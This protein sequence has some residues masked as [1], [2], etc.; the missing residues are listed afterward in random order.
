MKKAVLIVLATLIA[1]SAVFAAPT[2]KDYP[3][4]KDMSDPN[5]VKIDKFINDHSNKNETAVFD[6]DGT[7]Y[8]EKI[9]CK[10]FEG[11]KDQ[12]LP[13]QVS[14]LVYTAKNA[15]KFN[16]AVYPT[17]NH[18]HDTL[19]NNVNTMIKI[20]ENKVKDQKTSTNP[21][22][23]LI[24]ATFF[25]LM[26][27]AQVAETVE[28]FLQEETYR[29][30][31][32]MY[33]PMFDVFQKMIDSG[34]NVYIITGSNEYIV[35]KMLDNI[36]SVDYNGEKNYTF[37]NNLTGNKER[38]YE[39][40]GGHIMGNSPYLLDG[41]TGVF[42]NLSDY[43]WAANTDGDGKLYVV[44]GKGKEYVMKNIES[45]KHTNVVFVAG[46][47]DGDFEETK[48]VVDKSSDTMGLAVNA[49]G[50]KYQQLIKDNLQKIVSI[51][52][53]AETEKI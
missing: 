47:S 29:V 43:K 5:L 18:D 32:N 21:E 37:P 26:T 49:R 23:T 33:R 41:I 12:I 1:A 34:I 10:E 15:M 8:E 20:L 16:F 31:N 25:A 51:E 44:D 52:C 4:W 3:H 22:H 24:F 39:K 14:Y 19:F 36:K 46:N 53:A 38:P 17:Y 13:G 35:S 9:T 48:Y 30:E 40:D 7:L 50:E 42:S 2:K 28:Q 45:E 11:G 6:W 27:P